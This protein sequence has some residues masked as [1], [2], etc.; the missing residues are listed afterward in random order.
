[1]AKADISSTPQKLFKLLKDL[2][3]EE[4]QRAITATLILFGEAHTP[5]AGVGSGGAAGTPTPLGGGGTGGTMTA[6]QFFDQKQPKGRSEE[7]AVAV[8]YLE[9][10]REVGSPT[11]EQISE[12]I[13][14]AK[15]NFDSLHF[16]RDMGNARTARLFN[17]GKLI[18]L[19]HTGDRYVDALPDREAAAALKKGQKTRK[20]GRKKTGKNR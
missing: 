7:L 11:K 1:M 9:Q 10:H 17:P 2:T 6:R 20:G 19:S 5:P 14:N 12:V 3:S 8:R 13:T 18:Q 15:R 16:S 4:R